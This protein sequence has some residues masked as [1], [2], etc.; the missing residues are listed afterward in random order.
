M[1]AKTNLTVI[2]DAVP[3]A[4][5]GLVSIL[6]ELIKA[7]LTFLVLLTTLVGFYLGSAEPIDFV[8][9]AHTLGG[10]ALLA[11]GAAALN[12]LIER[13]HDARMRRTQGR[14]LPAG[15]VTPDS[16]LMFGVGM[17]IGGLA[18]LSW[19]AN[20][21]AAVL[22]AAT[23]ASYLFVYTPLK[24]IT[25]LN[26][27]VGAVPGALP[28]LIGWAAATGELSAAG[29]ALF[30]IVFFWQLPHFMAI[31]WLYRDDY[32]SA[33]FRMLSGQDPE[34][35]RT[36][37][38]ALRNT[39]ALLLIS[40]LPFVQRTSG[41]WYLLVA[42]VLG[43]VFLACAIRFARHLSARS[44]RQ[45]FFA[46]IL[47]LPLLLGALVCDKA[48]KLTPAMATSDR[49]GRHF[50]PERESMAAPLAQTKPDQIVN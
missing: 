34:G 29:W 30:A 26:T 13:E 41:G 27:L 9:L 42:A 37:A 47:Y 10:T 36:A 12:Q 33:G 39:M 20:L 48:K 46:S 2:A 45:L 25:V 38:S 31:C 11:A 32:S 17:V 43:F 6:S 49:I 44:A 23:V 22:G 3:S 8:L 40:F 16:V 14:P 15:H 35:H 4:E 24:R 21:L 50:S 5:P 18:W 1:S 28:P 7:R 19:G